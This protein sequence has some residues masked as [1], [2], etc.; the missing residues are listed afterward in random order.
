M[1]DKMVELIVSKLEILAHQ[2]GLT[3]QQ[4]FPYFVKQQIIYGMTTLICL[5]ISIIVLGVSF[6]FMF[7]SKQKI[8]NTGCVLCVIGGIIFIISILVFCCQGIGQLYN[9]EYFAIKNLIELVK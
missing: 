4:I 6:K 5:I 2:L 9:S 8:E 3:A 7:S 1:T